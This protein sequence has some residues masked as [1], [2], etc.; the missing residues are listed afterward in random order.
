M[1][2]YD[3]YNKTDH[4]GHKANKTNAE[5]D[6]EIKQQQEY[7]DKVWDLNKKEII[8]YQVGLHGTVYGTTYFKISPDGVIDPYTN[9]PYPRL[10][11]LDPEIIRVKT[12]PQDM[13]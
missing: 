5:L 11:A 1:V 7:L 4:M 9:K 12:A 2:I 8:L 6:E 10:I 3:Y 13:N